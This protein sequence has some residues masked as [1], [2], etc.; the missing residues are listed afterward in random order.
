MIIIF[1]SFINFYKLNKTDFWLTNL[2]RMRPH[3][4]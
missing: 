2:Y 1:I 4:N 3:E